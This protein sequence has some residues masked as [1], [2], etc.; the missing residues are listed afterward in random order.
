MSKWADVQWDVPYLHWRG[1]IVKD[2]P[3]T[4]CAERPV[5][6]VGVLL[7]HDHRTVSLP[8]T[9]HPF[10]LLL[11]PSETLLPL[12]CLANVK[13]QDS[14]MLKAN[15]WGDCGLETFSVRNRTLPD[16]CM[17]PEPAGSIIT[18][19]WWSVICDLSVYFC[20]LN[21]ILIS[22]VQ[23]SY[24]CELK[25]F[26]APQSKTQNLLTF[27]PH[28]LPIP[29]HLS[30]SLHFWSFYLCEIW[31]HIFVELYNLYLFASCSFQLDIYRRVPVVPMFWLAW[32]TSP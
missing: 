13:F 32:R 14:S 1:S 9:Q 3:P 24:L 28:T 4:H 29:Y 10:Y 25:T 20:L 19:G 18:A 11:F 6:Q 16:I 23:P 7:G 8:Q 31:R 5:G 30:I 15:D 22:A 21:F 27:T 12:S 26:S 17:H 2:L